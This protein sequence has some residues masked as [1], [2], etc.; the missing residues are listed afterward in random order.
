MGGLQNGETGQS[1]RLMERCYRLA[2]ETSPL[3]TQ[4]RDTVIVSITPV[5]DPDGRDRNVDWFY[6]GLDEQRAAPPAAPAPQRGQ[7]PEAG[8]PGAPGAPRAP[9]AR[10]GGG[11][12]GPPRRGQG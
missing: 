1:E 2:A 6:K 9:A 10:V 8:G 11:G 5:A 3:I 7:G 4:I 12:G